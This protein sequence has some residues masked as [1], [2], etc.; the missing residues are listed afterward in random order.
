MS[1]IHLTIICKAIE[2]NDMMEIF[3]IFSK[4]YKKSTKNKFGEFLT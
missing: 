3:S 1:H 4:K 2:I